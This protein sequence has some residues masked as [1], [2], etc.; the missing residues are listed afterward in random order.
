MI[1]LRF[2]CSSLPECP[3][4]SANRTVSHTGNRPDDPGLIPVVSEEAPEQIG[5]GDSAPVNTADV[6]VVAVQEIIVQDGDVEADSGQ[7]DA[8]NKGFAKAKGKWLFWLN[9]DDV[10]LPGALKKV[11]EFISRVELVDRVD[12]IAGD[13]C[14]KDIWLIISKNNMM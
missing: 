12:W 14:K 6:S 10:L 9:A 13:L 4:D 5:G 8:L 1:I 3:G 11:R 2:C 7:S